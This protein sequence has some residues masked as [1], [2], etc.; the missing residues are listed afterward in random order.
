MLYA[1]FQ[2]RGR[3]YGV[4]YLACSS[5]WKI[6]KQA[7]IETQI[8]VRIPLEFRGPT[9]QSSKQKSQEQRSN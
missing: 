4:Y 9:H 5:N 1:H 7:I 3:I 8:R 6:S 2:W